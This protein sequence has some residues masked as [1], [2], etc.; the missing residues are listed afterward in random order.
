[1]SSGSTALVKI[2]HLIYL[3]SSLSRLRTPHAICVPLTAA[4]VHEYNS[5][6]CFGDPVSDLTAVWIYV[7]IV[8]K[9][10]AESDSPPVLSS[11]SYP[12]TIVWLHISGKTVP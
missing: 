8:I 2:L 5:H 11:D 9:G 1:M 3:A 6:L 12:I 10:V 4:C 7:I